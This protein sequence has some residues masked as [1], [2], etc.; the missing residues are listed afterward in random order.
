MI[1]RRRWLQLGAGGLIFVPAVE[2][3]GLR[4]RHVLDDVSVLDVAEA[5]RDREDHDRDGNHAVEPLVLGFSTQLDF[6][7]VSVP[8]FEREVK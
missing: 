3:I 7:I 1:T 2:R 6:H 8:F 4:L 5:G